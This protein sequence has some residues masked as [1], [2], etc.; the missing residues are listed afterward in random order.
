MSSLQIIKTAIKTELDALVTAN[1]LKGCAS[2]DMRKDPLAGDIPA[3][4]Y[5]YLMPPST[6]SVVVDNRT[7]LRTYQF[8]IMVVVKGEKVNTDHYIEDLIEAM[9]N[10]FDNEPTLNGAADGAV[11]PTS[12]A[13]NAVQHKNGSL[14]VFFVQL[15]ANK[16]ETLTY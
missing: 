14:T 6:S 16:T 4:P 7:L 5:A 8:D 10:Q 11:E 2:I 1:V 3:T 15:K 13:P 9:L 12:S